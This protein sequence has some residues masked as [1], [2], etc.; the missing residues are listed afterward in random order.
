[1]S[2]ARNIVRL[3]CAENTSACLSIGATLPE[4]ARAIVFTFG[5]G[6]LVL[7]VLGYLLFVRALPHHATI[8]LSLIAGGGLVT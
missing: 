8:A 2:F 5:I 6:V 3:Q 7:G 4:N 1:M